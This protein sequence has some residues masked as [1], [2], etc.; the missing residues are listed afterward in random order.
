MHLQIP[1]HS[2]SNF[3]YLSVDTEREREKEVGI[4]LKVYQLLMGY[5]NPKF[6]S[7]E[8]ICNHKYTINSHLHF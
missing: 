7:L 4:C 5:L 1:F 8:N 3:L 2:K 6:D